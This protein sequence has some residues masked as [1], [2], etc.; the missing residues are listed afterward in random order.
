MAEVEKEKENE[1][2]RGAEWEREEQ[3]LE[4]KDGAGFRKKEQE[5]LFCHQ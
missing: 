2:R 1:K 4:K 3:R 5:F